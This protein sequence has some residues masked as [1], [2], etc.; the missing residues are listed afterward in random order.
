MLVP[1]RVTVGGP[2][3]AYWIDLALLTISGKVRSL[4][5]WKRI[6]DEVGL[7][8]VEVYKA[9]DNQTVMLETRLKEHSNH[10]A[11]GA[12]LQEALLS[13]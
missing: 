1:D 11:L 3:T 2:F 12:E 8:L 6:F 4:R 5:E 9:G 13:E 7:E 10:S